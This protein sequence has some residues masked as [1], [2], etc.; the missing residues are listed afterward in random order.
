MSIDA[1]TGKIIQNRVHNKINYQT[2]FTDF[3]TFVEYCRYLKSLGPVESVNV[4]KVCGKRRSEFTPSWKNDKSDSHAKI[5]LLQYGLIE[6]DSTGCYIV[7]EIGDKFINLFNEKNEIVVS[8]EEFLEVAFEMIDAWHQYGNGFDIHPGRMILKLMIEPELHGYFTDQDLAC[9]CNDI[10]NKNDNQYDEIKQKVIAFRA[11][12]KIFT[13]EEK[14][15]TYTLLTGY[16]NNWNI[17]ILDEKSTNE[18]KIVRLCEDFRKVVTAHLNIITED[19]ILSDEEFVSLINSVEDLNNDIKEWEMKYGI[20][21]KVIV[22]HKTRVK[23]VQ[24]AFRNRLMAYYDHKCMLCS[25][26]NKE[27][28]IASHIK[29]DADCETIAEKIDREN[30]FLLCANHD[31]AFDHYLITFDFLDGAIRISKSLSEEERKILMLDS[32]YVLPEE[33]LTPGRQQYL[34]FHNEEFEKREAKRSASI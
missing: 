9:I 10:M 25:M 31:K 13:R 24:D 12:G 29:R 4:N 17:F 5:S 22:T 33:Y 19:T 7:S 1:I 8:R 14:K 28:L 30:G 26:K 15:K 18:I 34:L 23:Q 16:A 32:D 3:N 21:G 27:M 11:S 6:E 2:S 20:D